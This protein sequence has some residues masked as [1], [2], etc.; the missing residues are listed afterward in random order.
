MSTPRFGSEFDKADEAWLQMA[1]AEA[2]KRVGAQTQLLIAQDART[3]GV[4]AAAITLALASIAIIVDQ[5]TKKAFTPLLPGA[6]GV[7]IA[8]FTSAIMAALALWPEGHEPI[9]WNPSV[10]ARDL[11]R[12]KELLQ[13]KRELAA[14]MSKRIESNRATGRKLAIRAR[15]AIATLLA[16]PILATTLALVVTPTTRP[17][18]ILVSIVASVAAIQTGRYLAR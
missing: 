4:M 10:L 1:L 3:L 7:A 2:D 16:S 9:G 11:A 5:L 8:A 17:I 14:H 13:I 15:L 12:G 18:G 6:F